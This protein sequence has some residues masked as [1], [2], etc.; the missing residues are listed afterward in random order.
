[1]LVE[2][3]SSL[4]V[5]NVVNPFAL[6]LSKTAAIYFLIYPILQLSQAR[7]MKSSFITLNAKLQGSI[8]IVKIILF[9]LDILKQ[10]LG[11]L[12]YDP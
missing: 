7:Y 4:S 10:R 11:C 3:I 1:M 9:W 2:I 6:I 8:S 5:Y 12:V